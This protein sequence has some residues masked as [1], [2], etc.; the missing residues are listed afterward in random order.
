MA[1][2]KNTSVWFLAAGVICGLLAAFIVVRG[3]AA[4]TS[5]MPVVAATRDIPAFVQVKP[6]MVKVIQVPRASIR[7]GMFRDPQ[8]VVGRYTRS[9]I[10]AGTPVSQAQ[11]VKD[12]SGGLLAASVTERGDKKLRAFAVPVDPVSGLGD[13]VQPGDRVDVIA[14]VKVPQGGQQ[15]PVA[16]IIAQSVE[17]IDYIAGSQNARAG[18]VLLVTPQQA[19]DIRF[20]LENG[21]ISVALN[22]YE[23]DVSASN[24]A[25]TTG[26]NFARTYLA[27]G[28]GK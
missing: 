25:P 23:P 28:G 21:K 19:Q 2:R 8:G 15:V 10:P 14:S 24:T 12:S 16:K 18:L 4:A 11:L 27:Q 7:P 3:V 9:I 20:A 1:R 5:A 6:D 26:E 17:V 22:P 13:K